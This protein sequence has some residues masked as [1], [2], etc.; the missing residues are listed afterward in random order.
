[1]LENWFF[2]S[3]L[4]VDSQN[5]FV[6]TI[7]CAQFNPKCAKKISL[8]HIEWNYP[9][10]AH[11]YFT[12]SIIVELPNGEYLW[13]V[14][15]FDSFW[16]SSQQVH[17]QSS[18]TK[19]GGTKK[20]SLFSI[21][22]ERK[23]DFCLPKHMTMESSGEKSKRERMKKRRR[24]VRRDMFE[25]NRRCMLSIP[26]P[27]SWEIRFESNEIMTKF[28]GSKTNMQ[29]LLLKKGNRNVASDDMTYFGCIVKIIKIHEISVSCSFFFCSSH[30]SLK[31]RLIFWITGKFPVF[32]LRYCWFCC[33][34]LLS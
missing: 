30:F 32:H 34:L 12:L 31:Y 11:V 2:S 8:S 16:N 1:M 23:T 15:G 28:I 13:F 5:I 25:K 4:E 19:W 10:N 9:K 29:T 3:C 6:P 18:V 14:F 17:C 20:P 33:C 21:K 27:F 7:K 26:L 24:R 22:Y